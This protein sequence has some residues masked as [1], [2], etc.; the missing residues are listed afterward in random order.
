MSLAIVPS[1]SSLQRT[2]RAHL[3]SERAQSRLSQADLADRAGVSRY[4]I[5]RLESGDYAN[6]GLEL[7]GKIA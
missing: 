5:V 1:G 2:L 7:L 3:I 6:P 4:T